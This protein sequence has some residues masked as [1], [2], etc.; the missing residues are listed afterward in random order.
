MPSVAVRA[1]V[2]AQAIYTALLACVDG[3]LGERAGRIPLLRCA[4]L[5]SK[6]CFA[7]LLS[8]ILS[9]TLSLERTAHV[10]EFRKE[11]LTLA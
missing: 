10:A 3:T 8:V 7:V 4:C 6:S 9:T 11:S 2:A 1:T 5:V